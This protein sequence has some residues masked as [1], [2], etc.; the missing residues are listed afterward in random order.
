[1]PMTLLEAIAR[2]EGFY[3]SGSR[4]NRN[5]NPGDIEYG[6]FARNHGADSIEILGPHRIPRF[7]HFPT[8]EL[9]FIAMKILFAEHYQGL[10]VGQAI[11][12]YAPPVENDTNDYI[13]NICTWANCSA[14][15]SITKVLGL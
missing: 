4:S 15:D 7:A 1:M 10:D 8:P 9:G 2:Q 6:I 12:K 13:K 5:N 3:V 11:L 14:S